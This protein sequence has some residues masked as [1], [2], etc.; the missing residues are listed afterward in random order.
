MFESYWYLIFY[1]LEISSL[2]IKLR[3]NMIENECIYDWSW[4]SQ[5]AKLMPQNTRIVPSFPYLFSG[6]RSCSLRRKGIWRFGGLRR[7]VVGSSALF[8]VFLKHA[9]CSGRAFRTFQSC[10]EYVQKF[11][12][13]W[14]NF[15]HI[16][17]Y[18]RCFLALFYFYGFK[19]GWEV[20]WVECIDDREQ[21]LSVDMW[22]A[23]HWK[24]RNISKNLRFA[25]A[26]IDNFR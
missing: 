5:I 26:M 4:L 8:G 20:C 23:S 6:W 1:S 16:L 24:V 13:F 25:D 2:T 3:C 10:I 22:F 18:R 17:R 15:D 9:K 7:A 11:H 14:P 12:D 19:L 21:E